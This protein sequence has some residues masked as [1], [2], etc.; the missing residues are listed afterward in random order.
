M[1]GARCLSVRFQ[2]SVPQFS[3]ARCAGPRFQ[4]SGS[5]YQVRR[6]QVPGARY[7]VRRFQVP[8]FKCKP[9][10]PR[11]LQNFKTSRFDFK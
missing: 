2:V 5:R 11:D 7:Q 8:D 10:N 4:V 9:K 1:P 6:F 3:G